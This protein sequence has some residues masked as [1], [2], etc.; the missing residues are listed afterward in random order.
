M[1]SQNTPLVVA[2]AS[3]LADGPFWG[4]GAWSQI[5]PSAIISAGEGGSGEESLPASVAPSDGSE[6]D[7]GPNQAASDDKAAPPE[8]ATIHFDQ[9]GAPT[10]GVLGATPFQE[11]APDT[12]EAWSLPEF[13]SGFFATSSWR[14]AGS[15]TDFGPNWSS[16]DK[17]PSS[18]TPFASLSFQDSSTPISVDLGDG[19]VARVPKVLLLG[20]SNTLGFEFSGNRAE[21]DGYRAELWQR[22]ADAGA[23]VDYVGE[24]QNG[25]NRLQ[26]ADHQGIGGLTARALQSDAGRIAT[27]FQPDVV[28]LMI[29][30]NDALQFGAAA[31]QQTPSDILA[32]LR[33]IHDA[34][35]SAQIM[36]VKPPPIDASI[37]TERFPH[38]TF[39]AD[40]PAALAT[41]TSAF[42]EI[43]AAAQREGI[44]VS[45]V[46]AGLSV[47]SL[48][49]GI[50]PS[51]AGYATL[52]DAIFHEVL[53]LVR[54]PALLSQ[55]VSPNVVGTS[56]GDRLIGDARAN[57]LDG[58]DGADLLNGAG[59]SDRLTGGAGND[60][61]V[62]ASA[63]EAGD[64]I[65][66]FEPGRDLIRLSTSGFGV[67][68]DTSEFTF[69]NGQGMVAL[70]EAPSLVYDQSTGALTLYP[71]GLG[72][73]AADGQSVL[74]AI[75]ENRPALTADDIV[76]FTPPENS[77]P[78]RWENDAPS[79][80]VAN[81]GTITGAETWRF[82]QTGAYHAPH[83]GLSAPLPEW[84]DGADPLAW[85]SPAMDAIALA[86]TTTVAPAPIF[87]TDP[88]WTGWEHFL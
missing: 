82:D 88:Y 63:H 80:M 85:P 19:T 71:K 57:D 14:E 79:L 15:T 22:L 3:T 48:A 8:F 5:A 50:H 72:S 58:G 18:D 26:D 32:V 45:L 24:R 13:L 46:D 43:V 27:A 35:P 76:F 74:V 34:A 83:E 30:T 9:A 10:S 44:P 54:D 21:F 25:P 33:A 17:A 42:P 4:V 55:A 69:W 81:F 1:T 51:T 62:F 38:I 28:V 7:A 39:A 40:A 12:G 20:D 16:A 73:T 41:I 86:A 77:Q 6:T 47:S 11:P 61:F 59:G 37:Y 70:S 68:A 52:A 64:R 75:F 67:M 53:P 29:G 31:Q 66:D 23:W 87:D 49:D 36:L 56:F 60:W 65:V 78:A 84:R 2:P